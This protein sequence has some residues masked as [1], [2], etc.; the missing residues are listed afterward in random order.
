MKNKLIRVL[1]IVIGCTAAIALA[2]ALGLENSISCGIITILSIQDTKRETLRSA[3]GR[4]AAFALAVACA[5]AAFAL[6][7][8]SVWSFGVFLLLFA[9]I[10]YCLQLQSN[11]PICTVLV[12][13]FWLAQHM[14]VS[15][16]INEALLMLIGTGIGVVLNLLVPRNTRAIRD[17]Q[18][19]I[20][21]ILRA[22]FM[23]V[24]SALSGEGPAEKVGADLSRLEAAIED[25]RRQA[26]SL[27]GN[28]LL[29]D[30]RYFV[31]YVDMR[32]QQLET[33]RRV[34]AAVRSLTVCLPQALTLAAYMHEVSRAIR[35]RN[36][37]V[38]LLVALDGIRQAFAESALPATRAE[39]ETRAT[40]YRIMVDTEHFLLIKKTF[41]DGLTEEQRRLYLS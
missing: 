8:Y 2:M 12:S 16:I 14:Q 32:R 13:H 18:F 24:G 27:S 1:E 28:T 30:V 17:A 19:R 39:F 40:L 4:F 29:G 10:A 20:E 15:L 38:A 23:D 25:A 6:L 33:L 5:Y 41:V 7:G 36:D 37:A 35:E 26:D 9:L 22:Y 21:S 3:A 11:L 31:L 34:E